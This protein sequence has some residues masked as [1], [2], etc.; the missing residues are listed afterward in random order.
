M[1]LFFL[2]FASASKLLI[3]VP[4]VAKQYMTNPSSSLGLKLDPNLS[5][6]V[7]FFFHKCFQ[8]ILGAKSSSTTHDKPKFKI[9]FNLGFDLKFELE[10]K[11]LFSSTFEVLSM[12]RVAWWS[13]GGAQIYFSFFWV[14]NFVC[15]SFELSSNWIIV[16]TFFPFDLKILE[17]CSMSCL[18]V[19]NFVLQDTMKEAFI[20]TPT[21]E[22][23][24]VSGRTSHHLISNLTL[25]ISD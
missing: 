14:V 10:F 23:M 11:F 24:E 18:K 7:F 12:L 13:M 19:L 17:P 25:F 2:F 5:L 15:K 21:S 20:M 4:K 9:K 8:A 22:V 6:G 1:G 16:S 3:L